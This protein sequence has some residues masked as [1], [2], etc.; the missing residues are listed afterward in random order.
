MRH[1]SP[2]STGG[3]EN[4]LI[5][6]LTRSSTHLVREMNQTLFPFLKK[7]NIT[8]ESDLEVF[9]DRIVALVHV[10]VN[11]TTSQMLTI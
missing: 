11:S 2:V 3:V 10:S 5:S 7:R 4:G 1:D 9:E 8:K 6:I